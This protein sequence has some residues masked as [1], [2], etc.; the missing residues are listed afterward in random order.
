MEQFEV[1]T[2]ALYL[3]F[4]K[5]SQEKKSDFETA[6][7]VSQFLILFFVRILQPSCHTFA[8]FKKIQVMLRRAIVNAMFYICLFNSGNKSRRWETKTNCFPRDHTFSV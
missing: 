5:Q 3:L 7:K 6:L 4:E 8:V 1:K 2:G